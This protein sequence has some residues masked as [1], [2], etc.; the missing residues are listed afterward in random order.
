MVVVEIGIAVAPQTLMILLVD[1]LLLKY[2]S[3]VMVRRKQQQVTSASF[4]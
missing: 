1:G 3:L 2:S 4:P